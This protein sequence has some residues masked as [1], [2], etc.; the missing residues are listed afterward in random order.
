MNGASLASLQNMLTI[1]LG[2]SDDSYYYDLKRYTFMAFLTEVG[3][4]FTT[5]KMVFSLVTLYASKILLSREILN[6]LFFAR[7]SG[8]DAPGS[9]KPKNFR[10]KLQR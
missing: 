5:L 1:Q 3:G 2:F 9:G 10:E 6:N 7:N 4:L 8:R